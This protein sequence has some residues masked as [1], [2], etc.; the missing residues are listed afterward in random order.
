VREIEQEVGEALELE[1]RFA[2]VPEW[3]LDAS[4]SDC[5]VRLYAILLRYGQSSGARMPSRATLAQRLKK[6]STDT[7]DRS[8]RE[9]VDLGAVQVRARYAGRERLSNQYVVRSSRPTPTRSVPP[10]ARVGQSAVSG[11]GRK[12]AATRA[13]AA[14]GGRTDQATPAANLRPNRE[15]FTEST[16]PPRPAGRRSGMAEECEVDDW[17]AFVRDCAAGRSAARQPSTRWSGPCL[18]AA[19]QLA[20]RGRGW[21]AELAARALLIVAADPTSRSPMR[22]AEAGPWWDDAAPQREVA[23]SSGEVER[24][25]AELGEIGGLRV[26][27]Q[28]QARS[29]LAAEG[30]PVTRSTVALRSLAL[31]QAANGAVAV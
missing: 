26:V 25:E 18:D 2:I 1:E 21:P 7:V 13:V 20:V 4:I 31:L 5:A 24:A 6:R 12:F 17:D 28:K 27:L 16:P 11:G 30:R 8:M 22:V 10:S 3:L 14:G 9:L 15:F 29:Q 23:A 19:L